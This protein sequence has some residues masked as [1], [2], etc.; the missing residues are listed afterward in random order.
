MSKKPLILG[1]ESSCDETA[2]SLI[3]ENEEGMPIVLSNIIS[4]QIDIHKEFGGVVPELAA[5]SH[6][7]KI[8]W[9]VKKAI[10]ESGR[11]IK[12]I[13][14][15]ASTAGPGLIVC[16]S[17]G[18]SFGK[19]FASTINKPFIAVNH[20]EGHALSPKL[21][22]K[23]NYPYLLL[24]ISGGHSQYLSVQNLGKYKRLGTTID[25][26]LGE[27]FDK[28]AK[29]LG[30][31]FP[32]G[33]QIEVFAEK[34]DPNKYELPKPIF[35]KGGCN[36]SFAGLK[37][38]ILKISKT[39][40]TEQEKFDLAASFQKTI[41]DILYK[42]TKIAFNEF[43]KLNNLQEK[44]FVVAGGVAAN[45]KIRSMLVNLCIENNYESI[46][47]VIELCGD[48]AAMIAMVGLEKFKLKEFSDLD[49]PAKPRWPLD[50][51]AAFLK[52]AGV[53]L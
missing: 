15:V 7:E 25:D 42:K 13:D 43:E 40:N 32:G 9:I 38:A 19:A 31:E 51:K 16:L 17:V 1:I 5:R 50:E 48:N 44:K 24:L 33:P 18:L 53:Q 45:K 30:I 28:T 41:E 27:A 8:D 4:S 49:H 26:A 36:L 11:S 34:G 6:I 52:G 10:D 21:N 20:L 3:T 14:A 35:N 22:S 12:E 2:A 47:P 46:F 37:T 23:I 29:L 39:I